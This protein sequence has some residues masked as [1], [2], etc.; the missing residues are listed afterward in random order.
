MTKKFKNTKCIHCLNEF[1]ELTSDHVF[2]KSW[3][4]SATP[5]NI[6]K[7]QAPCCK[8][9]NHIYSKIEN[10]LLQRFGMCV[11]P[12]NDAAKGIAE[13]AMRSY[14]T[15]NAKTSKDARLRLKTRQKLISNLISRDQIKKSSLLPSKQPVPNTP[16]GILIPDAEYKKMGRKFIRGI[17]YVIN[18]AYIDSTHKIS[19]YFQNEVNTSYIHELLKEHGEK[20]SCGKGIIIERAVLP[21]DVQSGV[22][23]IELWE[24]TYMYGVVVEPNKNT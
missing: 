19:I 13:K 10:D 6:E 20:Y 15:Q 4:P 7:W 9:C 22:Y 17:T 14:K 11:D 16:F 12:D 2:P 8:D 24:T 5:E 23:Y 21:E 3:Y 18:S 1:S